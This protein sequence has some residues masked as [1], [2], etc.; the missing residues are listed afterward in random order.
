MEELGKEEKFWQWFKENEHTY[1]YYPD[2]PESDEKDILTVTIAFQLWD[3]C[4]PLNF[5]ITNDFYDDDIK[6]LMITA[7]CD[8]KLFGQ[9]HNL[10]KY[11]PR[12]LPHWV[13][14]ALIP[15][16]KAYTEFYDFEYKGI[17]LDSRDIWFR[18]L[19]N[20]VS[21]YLFGVMIFFKDYDIY[22]GHEH[23]GGAIGRLL[24]LELGEL[25]ATTNI[26]HIDIMPLPPDPEESE[27][28]PLNELATEIEQHLSN[29]VK[30]YI[31]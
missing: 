22:H 24:M 5:M 31:N 19:V 1:Y 2:M 6:H 25:S 26:H 16:A 30:P 12:D 13:F 4:Y 15:P 11:A 29:K 20:S 21:P 23:I 27:C 28:K 3:Y 7:N 8:E 14:H 18:K 17:I 9:V 10:V